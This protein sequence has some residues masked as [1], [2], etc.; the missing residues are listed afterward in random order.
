[1]LAVEPAELVIAEAQERGRLPLMV[2][3]GPEGTTETLDLERGDRG[4]E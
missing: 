1:M 2:T 4:R 3:G